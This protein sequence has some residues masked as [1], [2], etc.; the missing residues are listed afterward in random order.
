MKITFAAMQ[1]KNLT[2]HAAAQHIPYTNEEWDHVDVSGY[3]WAFGRGAF[4][5][6][7]GGC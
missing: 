2:N 1:H 4:A 7:A 5:R 6:P 3:F